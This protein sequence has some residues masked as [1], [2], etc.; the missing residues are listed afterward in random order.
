MIPRSGRCYL[1]LLRRY[2]AA[3]VLSLAAQL[4]RLPLA[5]PT[6]IPYITYVPFIVTAGALGGFGPGLLATVL[7]TLESLYYAT[8]PV[9]EFAASQ[10]V[11]C[12]GLG[13]L[14]FT[15]LLA[16]MLLGRLIR[17]RREATSAA[18][19][20]IQ[21]AEEKEMR[22]HLLESMVQ[23]SP[24]AMALLVGKDFTF[25]MLNPSYQA[26]A[27]GEP[28]AGRTVSEVWPEAAP[29][30]LPLLQS[31]RD[32]G[33]AFHAREFAVP[34]HRVPGRP[35]EK[36]YFDFSYVPLRGYAGADDLAVLVAANEVTSYKAAE[37]SL[38]AAYSELEAIYEHAPVVLLVVDEQLRVQKVNELA[39][40]FAG[41]PIPDML[42]VL[43][44]TAIGCGN[45][46]TD[47]R[48]CGYGADCPRCPI[49][50]SVLDALQGGTGRRVEGWLPLAA[51]GGQQPRCL[52][53]STAAMDFGNGRKVLVCAQ[54]IT[55]LKQAQLEL[56]RREEALQQTVARLQTALADKTVLLQEVHHRVKNNLAVISSLLVMKADAVASGEARAALAESQQRVHSIALIHEHLY[57]NEHLDRI[58]F[59]EYAQQLVDGIRAAAAGERFA[60]ETGLE[61]VE[62]GIERAVPCALVLNELLSNALKYAF[63]DGRSGR[64]QVQ[65]RE[66]QAGVLELAV[67]DNGVG[68]PPGG[69]V[70]G[71]SKSL[72][73]QIVR[74]LARQLDGAV[75]QEACPGTRIVL[76]FPAK[77]LAPREVI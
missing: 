48:G 66:T 8:D 17:T 39:S 11:H 10:P 60:I 64:I 35:A 74:I 59:A 27:P 4:A 16:S 28:M 36:R 31:V 53:V 5:S 65:F 6:S 50:L 20:R 43:P 55:E 72:G 46:L 9:G 76:R 49:R 15:G 42:G 57:G 37:E 75:E 77:P 30:V 70:A 69:L 41:R 44:G 29:L 34:L 71:N 13:I 21:L 52:L 1:D 33:T 56:L 47:P 38:S 67:E 19:T 2:G 61:A 73:L 22:Q 40:R 14:A 24:A 54:D 3:L 12:V 45:C 68:L 58:D 26:L 51:D 18:E 63:P 7:C 25:E 62:L 32:T 23:N